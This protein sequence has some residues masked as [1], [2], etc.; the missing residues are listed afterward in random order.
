[1][2]QSKLRRW[3][4][5]GA[6]IA[7]VLVVDQVSKQTVLTTM[8]V[9]ES[10]QPIPAL[11]PYFQITFSENTGSAFGFLPQASDAFLI[12]AVVVVAAMIVFYQRLPDSARLSRYAFG[13]VCGGAL[14][15]ALDRVQHGAVID[16]IHYRL[17]GVVSNVSNLADHAIVVGVI[18]IFID[19]WRAD[20]AK[21][22]QPPLE[23]ESPS[24]P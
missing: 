22:H 1:M 23:H 9:G 2:A 10:R 18:M 21:K 8:A 3:L 7:A 16:F 4:T 17:P 12:I 14:G 11:Y 15:N 6:I 24:E 5:L 19:S 13:L 20:L